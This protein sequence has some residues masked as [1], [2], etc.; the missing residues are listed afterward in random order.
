VNRPTRAAYV[1]PRPNPGPE[2]PLDQGPGTAWAAVVVCT[3]TVAVLAARAARRRRAHAVRSADAPPAVSAGPLGPRAQVIASADALRAALATRFGPAWRARTTEEIVR[4]PVL[5]ERLDAPRLER[6][7][8]LLRLADRA[9]FAE[10]PDA[11]FES[12]A[13]GE[14]LTAELLE[15]LRPAA[16]DARHV[17]PTAA[18]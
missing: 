11:H 12:A 6:L 9:K 1:P 15:A 16:P 17:R 13:D 2:P 5:A 8:A 14:R 18:R 10:E 3:V 7:H 4:D